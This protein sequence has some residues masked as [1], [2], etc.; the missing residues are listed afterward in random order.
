M[1]GV[2]FIG[3]SSACFAL[4]PVFMRQVAGVAPLGIAFYR[5]LFGALWLGLFAAGVPSLR[6]ELRQRPGRRTLAMLALLGVLM[7]LASGLYIFAILQTTIAKAML[8]NYMAPLYVA[9]VGPWLLHEAR[10]GK[11]WLA[12]G[13]G[14]AGM[15]LIV[16]PGRLAQL[17]AGEGLGIVAAALSG[18][19]YAAIIILGRHLVGRISPFVRVLVSCGV[20][21][22]MF[23]PWA[24]TQ[25]A[26]AVWTSLPWLLGIGLI[27]TAM[28]FTFFFRGQA[29]VSAH[30]S[31]VIALLEPVFGIALGYLLL[32]ENLSILGI[33]GAGVILASIYLAVK[34]SPSASLGVDC[35]DSSTTR[36]TKKAQGH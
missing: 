34:P 8:L 4:S 10:S 7:G 27:G 36:G 31:G 32:G 30:T 18:F 13:L 2:I 5:A 16:E 25:P 21:L 19:C 33:A 11:V 35:R 23:A 17:S 20:M 6:V 28:S 26:G 14:V 15:V 29:Y 22:P 1:R 9:V 24:V 12:A 3:L